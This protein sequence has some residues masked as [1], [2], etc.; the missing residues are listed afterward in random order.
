MSKNQLDVNSQT[1]GQISQMGFAGQNAPQN[2]GQ[3]GQPLAQGQNV[4]R[5]PNMGQIM[6]RMNQGQMFQMQNQFHQGQFQNQ[7]QFQQQNFQNQMNQPVAQNYQNEN[8]NMIPV[9]PQQQQMMRPYQ[10]KLIIKEL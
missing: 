8:Q 7:A 4:G 9:P 1:P 3:M 6:G 5:N 2:I 10:G